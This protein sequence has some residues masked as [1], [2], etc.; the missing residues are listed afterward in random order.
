M[1]RFVLLVGL[2]LIASLPAVAQSLSPGAIAI[3]GMN[4]DSPDAFAFVALEDL[5]AG[6]EIIF[7]DNGWQ[8]SG[9]FRTDEGTVTYTVPQGGLTAGA[10]VTLEGPDIGTMALSNS[11]DQILA[12][13]GTEDD[14]SFL[15]A[16]NVEGNA[17]WQ[18]DA[19][20]AHTSALP[21]QLVN[22]E[23]AI[24]LE[25]FDN[26]RYDSGTVGTCDE[27]RT[28]IS[29][30]S[31]WAG[32]DESRLP[33]VTNFTVTGPCEYDGNRPPRFYDALNDREITAGMEFTY[34]YRT[35]DPDRDSLTFRLVE[36][37]E[38]A[39][40]EKD[41]TFDSM[42]HFRWTPPEETIGQRFEV[43]VQISDGTF[44]VDT[45]ATLTVVSNQAPY[46]DLIA[47]G[48][49]TDA[50]DALS[51]ELEWGAQDP[52]GDPLTFAL[53]EGPSEGALDVD[54]NRVTFRFTSIPRPNLYRIAVRVSDGMRSARSVTA[55]LLRGPLFPELEGEVLR[56]WL[57]ATYKP[58][59][60]LGYDH[61]IDT[62]FAVIDRQR[63]GE[64]CGIYTRYC[65]HLP[66]G[67]DPSDYLASYDDNDGA[68][69]RSDGIVAEHI[70]PQSKGAGE[71]PQRSDMHILFPAKENVQ[72]ARGDAP[73][74]EI[75]DEAT[76][77]WYWEDQVRSDLPTVW[78][79]QWSEKDNQNPDSHYEAR[80]ESR[81]TTSGDVARA[82]FYFYVMYQEA[83]DAADP[84]FFEAQLEDLSTWYNFQSP[85]R[86]TGK[87]RRSAEIARYQGNTN[88]FL[89]DPTLV[90]RLFDVGSGAA[91]ANVPSAGPTVT[92]PYPNP[93]HSEARFA[94]HVQ[95]MQQVE[96]TVYDLLGRSVQTALDETLLPETVREVEVVTGALPAGVYLVR[97]EGEVFTATRKLVVVR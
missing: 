26:Y 58:D 37:P 91:D 32:L 18:D 9:S 78:R 51:I 60:T 44:K 21:R 77:T 64:V 31:N 67:V 95:Q 85:I 74:A 48:A 70:W 88:P 93:A 28:F 45:S 62:V 97:T 76:D 80:F 94:V 54:S 82:A 92:T 11:G 16:L 8:V 40:I 14:P 89:V 52:E 29:E 20:N 61:A 72:V 57:R 50:R 1:R 30:A 75:P 81:E 73:Y 63:N 68:N 56:D 36:A 39:I 71:E 66:E 46:Y 24:A 13:Q 23:S 43:I 49:I 90:S 59:Q 7:T 34:R 33:F 96:V 12:Y 35:T 19:T 84:N 65:I 53:E 6:T 38:G 10:V 42:A 2:L 3:V 4:T 86:S 83:A 22:G 41:G 79:D 27:L 5:A 17:Q 47:P 87:L 69:G 25:E 15:Y 55:I